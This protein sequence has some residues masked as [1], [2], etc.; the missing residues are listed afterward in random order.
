MQLRLEGIAQQAGSQAYLYPMSLAPAAGALT[1]LLGATQAGKTSLMRVMAGLDRPSAGQVL[2]DGTDVTGMP[3][4]ERNVS[5]VYQQFINYPSLR[6]F[7]NIASPL[8]LRGGLNAAELKATVRKLAARLHIDHLLDRYPAELSGGQQQRVALARALA[9]GAPL[10]LLDEPLVNLDY[11]LREELRD[12]LG[13]LFA[14]GDATVVYATTEP[15]EALLLGG[16]TAVLDAGEL[17]Q[18]GPTPDVFHYPDSLRVARAFS[19]PPMNLMAGTLQGGEVLL[20]GEVRLPVPDTAAKGG[21]V[22]V[23]VRAAAVHLTRVPGA[24]AVPGRVALAELSGSDTFVHADT[25]VGNLVAQLAGVHDLQPGATL[26]C[27]LDPSQLYLFDAQGRR[28]HAPARPAR[29]AAGH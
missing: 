24:V 20:A 14:H 21:P 23:G 15:A 29:V 11:K 18:Y 9:K 2:V 26:S 13:Q 27:W 17:L 7:D 19:D 3:V 6:V 16:H 25:P 10:V 1:I 12:E 28:I 8:R 22:T 5:M 4:R